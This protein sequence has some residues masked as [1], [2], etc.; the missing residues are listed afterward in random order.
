VGLQGAESTRW[1]MGE[2]GRGYN[3]TMARG[4]T[5]SIIHRAAELRR[6]P[7]PAEEK[8]WGY[9][10]RNKLYGV[11]FRRQHAIGRYIADFCSPEQKL[12]IELDGSEHL[13][14]KAEDKTRTKYLQ[15]AG[16]RVIRFWNNEVMDDIDGVIREIHSAF[17]EA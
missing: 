14:R 10:R 7:T 1:K 6:E 12:V 17:R 2:A 16:Y 3:Q 4:S 8:L 9:L 5:P 13:Q 15:A 11:G